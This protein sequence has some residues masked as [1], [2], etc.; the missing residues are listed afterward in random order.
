MPSK[1]LAA[2]KPMFKHGTWR[3]VE[4]DLVQILAG[5]DKGKQGKVLKVI[6]DERFPRVVVESLNIVSRAAHKGRSRARPPGAAALSSWGRG[7]VCRRL[8][9]ARRRSQA[10]PPCRSS[11][12]SRGK[13]LTR[14]AA[15]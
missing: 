9:R 13:A 10:P 12:T 4:G 15:C 5:K 8:P 14:P 3:I 6:K 2:I 11:A 1:P 7:H